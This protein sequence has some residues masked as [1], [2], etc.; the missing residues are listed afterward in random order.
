MA[1]ATPPSSNRPETGRREPGEPVRKSAVDARQG[2][3]S[4]RVLAI[5]A[6][7][8]ALIALA[9]ALLFFAAP[10]NGQAASLARPILAAATPVVTPSTA[11]AKMSLSQ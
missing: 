7:S 10:K 9:Y 2:G 6:I 8:V 11:P 1:N 3:G 4:R 5:L